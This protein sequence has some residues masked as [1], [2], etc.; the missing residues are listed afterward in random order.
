MGRNRLKRNFV[1]L[2]LVL[3]P[4]SLV[5]GPAFAQTKV[6][7]VDN[8][9]GDVIIIHEAGKKEKA[10]VGAPL[11]LKDVVEA[12]KE[13]SVQLGFQDGTTLV[14][15][16][17]TKIIVS[18][19]LFNPG[20]KQRETILDVAGGKL[21]AVVSKTFNKKTSKTEFRTP[22]AVIGVR[23][24][25]LA[26]DVGKKKTTVFC[27]KGLVSTLNPLMPLKEMMVGANQYSDVEAGAPPSSPLPIPKQVLEGI[28]GQFGFPTSAEAVKQRGIDTL[29]SRLPF[30]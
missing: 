1:F 30:P 21:K 4:W 7:K 10:A 5:H 29:K 19:F 2:L 20:K 9:L 23:G 27:L 11:F 28:E 16:E 22:T 12:K 8:V 3:G 6:G 13:S 25:E 17:K 15:R 14:L 18:E 24:T 26:L